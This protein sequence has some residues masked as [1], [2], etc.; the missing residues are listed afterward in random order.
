MTKIDLD[1]ARK[2]YKDEVEQLIKTHGNA[3]A[4]PTEE[5][6][7]AGEKLRA[8]YSINAQPELPYAAVFK[9]Y[10]IDYRVWPNFIDDPVDVNQKKVKRSDKYAAALVWASENVGA[11]VTLEKIGE[12]GDMS[13]TMAKKLAESQ[14]NVFR[15]LK[16]SL[17]QIRDPKVDREAE[18][19]ALEQANKEKGSEQ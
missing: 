2:T 14:P 6:Y 8:A 7:I 18:K 4:I 16:R 15:K 3:T 9:Q 17:W 12:A 5:R 19:A 11:E 10:A 13:V 1:L